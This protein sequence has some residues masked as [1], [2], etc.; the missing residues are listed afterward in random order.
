MDH[1]LASQLTTLTSQLAAIITMTAILIGI[2]IGNVLIAY[3]NRLLSKLLG[4]KLD[5]NTALCATSLVSSGNLPK[6]APCI[7]AVAK[8]LSG[9]QHESSCEYAAKATAVAYETMV[10]E[11]VPIQGPDVLVEKLRAAIVETITREGMTFSHQEDLFGKMHEM[12]VRTQRA[13]ERTAETEQRHNTNN[14]KQI[15]A[16]MEEI[17]RLKAIIAAQS[18]PSKE[19]GAS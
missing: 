12:L 15:E 2:G 10:R 4:T 14:V 1:D 3:L 6:S 19:A 18:P 9:D 8:A 13:S 11:G 7:P 17:A 16:N 5:G